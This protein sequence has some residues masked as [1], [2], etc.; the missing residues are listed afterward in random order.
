MTAVRNAQPVAA[1][2][3]ARIARRAVIRWAWRMF[4]RDLRS[5]FL[6]LTL[7]TLAVAGAVGGSVVAYNLAPAAGDARFGSAHNSLLFEN[8]DP[9][10]MGTDLAAAESWFETVD[11]IGRQ[12]A[13]VPGLFQP[14]ELRSQDPDGPFGAPMLALVEGRFPVAAD[15]VGI[16]DANA[17]L[18]DVVVGDTF[19]LA[20]RR[21]TV[22]GQVE[23]P[24]D[25]NDEFVLLAPVHLPGAESVTV[26]AGG[27][28]DQVASFR[29][30]SGIPVVASSRPANEGAGAAAGALVIAALGLA[31]VG[32]VA[33]AAFLVVAHR[34]L[35]QL[36]MLAAVGATEAH[37]RTVMISNGMAIGAVGGLLGCGIA[38]TGSL[39]LSPSLESVVGH[40]IDRFNVPWW[41]LVA[42]LLLAVTTATAAAWGPARTVAKVPIVS[43]LSGRPP[44]PR[45]VH[46]SL[47]LSFGLIGV[48]VASL[49]VAD[50]PLETPMDALL[51]VFGSF[52][53]IA[54]IVSLSPIA[55]RVMTR[56]GTRLPVGMRVALRDLSRH[57]GRA[58]SA[59][60]A[61]SLT[62]GVAIAIVIATTASLYASDAEGNLSPRQLMV[63]VGEI[64]GTGDVAP[65]PDR[66][67]S[68]LAELGA[69]A[70]EIAALLDDAT[71]TPVDVAVAP[72]LQGFG[73]VPAVVL[74]EEVPSDGGRLHHILTYLYVA[75]DVLLAPY[76]VDLD[77]LRSS[78]EVLTAE[79]GEIWYQP[80]EPE[81]VRNTQPLEERYTS[82]PSSFVTHEAMADR[83]WERARAG[84]LLESRTLVTDT[85]IADALE[86]AASAG[87][88]I[89]ARDKQADLA[90]VRTR[91]TI[92]GAVLALGIVA[93]AVGLVRNESAGELRTLT[94][95]GASSRVRR[96]LTATTAGGLA[97]LGVLLGVAGA[98]L[99]FVSWY[100]GELSALLPVPF[101]HLLA[102]VAG[103]P[104]VA[105]LAGWLLAGRQP[106]VIGRQAID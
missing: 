22:A 43:A 101:A 33:A 78:T 37:L 11:P 79:T 30:P 3:G 39:T 46:R 69:V 56:A 93:I 34:R 57:Q 20:D 18:L 42:C 74:A 36:G 24:S 9:D 89:E 75:S 48:G 25:L 15:E 95:V 68:E 32:L 10:A 103:I 26:L 28:G 40:R 6:V 2:G 17:A 87:L 61:L 49:L 62:L 53:L 63:R 91:A 8:A 1:D 38:L 23:N 85:Q 72:D 55:I 106:E 90:A 35:R 21:W 60:A 44:T 27:N 65:I 70:D 80:M 58:G 51:I 98:Y 52:A 76:G 50:D 88:T 77:S 45:Q 13:Q 31:A 83:G 86:L 96:T 16:T 59:L 84:W 67:P 73:G 41:L 19:G 102:I 64:P 100:W 14:V 29:P 4:R 97:L 71:S 5:Q 92:A 47:P 99:G 81:L 82:F 104:I 105:W 94:A 54:G 7:I 12:Y 66:S